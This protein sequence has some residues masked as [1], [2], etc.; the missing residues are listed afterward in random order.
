M[1]STSIKTSVSPEKKTGKSPSFDP[2]GMQLKLS[3]E[4]EKKLVDLILADKEASEQALA[5]KDYGW[6]SKGQKINFDGHVKG[7][8]D[9]YNARR[10]PKDIP[11][12]FC[13]NR[14]LRIATSILDT[15]HARIYPSIVN[16]ELTRWNPGETKD[17]PKVERI[18]KLM[19]WWLYVRSR[20]QESIDVWLKV[21]AGFGNSIAETIFDVEMVDTGRSLEKP[22]TDET[23]QPLA[24]E[25]GTPSVIKMRD[26][27]FTERTKTRTYL[28]DQFLLQKGS[29]DITKETVILK[30]SLLFHVL[31]QGE[32]EGKFKNIS[33]LLKE[34]LVSDVQ[35]SQ[36]MTDEEADKFRQLKVRNESV[37]IL[38]TYLNFDADGDGFPERVRV[39]ISPKHKLYLGGTAVFNLTK[40]GRDPLHHQKFDNRLDRPDENDGEGII[41]KVKELAEEID[42]IFNQLTDANTLSVLRPG[43]YDPSGDVKAEVLKL[44]PNRLVPISEPQRNVAFPDLTVRIDQLLAS[45]RLVL[46]FIERLTAASAFVFGKEGEFA[47]GSGTAT[48]TAAIMQSAD[49]RFARPAERMRLGAAAI[50]RQHLDI[51]QLNIPPGLESRIL[52]EKGEPV[53][54]SNELTAEGI[55]GEFDAFIMPDP[56]FGSKQMDRELTQM[57]YS[58]LIN[59]PLVATDPV[60][61]YKLLA[62]IIKSWDKDPVEYLGPAPTQDDIDDPQEENT[63]IVQGDFARV[64]PQIAENHLIHIQ[65]HM[66]LMNSPSLQRLPQALSSQII[67]YTTQHIQEHQQMLQLVMALSQQAVGGK[68]AGPSP[69]GPNGDGQGNGRSEGTPQ[70]SGLEQASGPLG[71]AL[72]RQRAGESGQT[73]PPQSG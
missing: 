3:E 9:L 37:D 47:G 63:L 55:S 12:K 27:R 59:E 48:R 42:A 32:S 30:D 20:I 19:K 69:Q 6:D 14:S 10:E 73:A 13:S 8:K 21:T 28:P 35:G 36:D 2:L 5:A 33:N 61:R 31:E 29:R 45:I 67:Q 65:E 15:I 46:E 57:F 17:K 50:L 38:K 43:F 23:G 49:T 64:R 58:I 66:N 41:E 44:A 68:N 71:A 53:F 4:A 34:M 62:D 16:E 39:I 60:K 1:A 7:V 51:L 52:G 18:S 70:P 24:E 11:W 26:I 54:E 40:S 22:V 72:N 25:D 56:A